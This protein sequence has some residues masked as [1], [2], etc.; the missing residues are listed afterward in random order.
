V[1]R[2]ER[3][4]PVV[5]SDY[6]MPG[7]RGDELLKHVHERSPETMTIMLT[8]HAD[9]RAVAN[10]LNNSRLFHFVEKPWT[11]AQL[12]RVVHDALRNY[13]PR[14]EA[15]RGP[16]LGEA[17]DSRYRSAIEVVADG[18][19]EWDPGTD[20]VVF[21]PQCFT[22]LGHKPVGLES[23]FAVL[24][25][26]V[27][28]E[29]REWV[30]ARLR[31]EAVEN[32]GG[33]EA[34]Y[35]LLTSSGETRWVL[36]RAR[37]LEP[38]ADGTPCR[39]VGSYVDITKRKQI[40]E[41]LRRAKDEAE[42]ALRLMGEAMEQARNMARKAERANLAKSAF[43]ANMSHE[44]RTPMNGIMGMARLL[45]ETG[46]NEEQREFVN[47]V[48][49]SSESL[50]ALLNDVLDLSRIEAECINL[51]H[52]AFSPERLVREVLRLVFPKVLEKNLDLACRMDM[53]ALPQKI[54]SDPIR[55]RQ[56]LQNLLSNAAK[57]T[58]VG[59]IILSL[60]VTGRR[61]EPGDWLCLSV[62]DSGIGLRADEIDRVFGPFVQGDISTTRRHGGTGLGL[63]IVKSLCRAMGGRVQVE[64]TPGRGSCFMVE[65]PVEVVAPPRALVGVDVIRDRRFLVLDRN[66][67]VGG[68]TCDMLADLSAKASVLTPGQDLFSHLVAEET[69]GRRVEVLVCDADVLTELSRRQ[70]ECPAELRR[71][72]LV[73]AA[74]RSGLEQAV[75]RA[76]GAEFDSYVRKPV[77]QRE[78][79]ERAVSLLRTARDLDTNAD[80]TRSSNP[81]SG[82]AADFGRGLDVLVVE[83]NVVN[84]RVARGLLTKM[85]FAV[86]L[87]ANGV[88]A[89]E[90]VQSRH[91]DVVFMDLHMPEMDGFDATRR[92]RAEEA[93]TDRH[94]PIIAMTANAMSGIRE[95]CLQTGMDG[96]VSK[97][98]VA[99]KLVAEMSRALYVAAPGDSPA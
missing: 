56:I 48:Y 39:V 46:L 98:V 90:R 28:P 13:R 96:Y 63:T 72:P 87:A 55:I 86:E 11:M 68:I 6:L 42:D 67:I 59:Q 58:D 5:I 64:S 60:E 75:D 32:R 7:M 43:L 53:T 89:C 93:G 88:E 77:T 22:M 97:P 74:L 57:F 41:D 66:P 44:I 99:E 50:L 36:G 34:E 12:L 51:Q 10:A 16:L 84:Q 62:T 9:L 35:R 85:G 81:L 17:S 33:F 82:L 65:L 3:Q 79:C 18:V 15:A 4:V 20:R 52:V 45:L 71:R 30:V 78:L 73:I 19:W 40:E 83:D 29:D 1:L 8:G 25:S 91:F 23:T 37:T 26:H 31:G 95:E 54:A 80:D 14:H 49:A 61:G 2:E 69:A 27:H 24:S 92:I 70:K 21:S 38:G 94:L 47:D 76:E